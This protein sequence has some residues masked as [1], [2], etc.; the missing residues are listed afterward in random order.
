MLVMLGSTGYKSNDHCKSA[1]EDVL[2]ED[3]DN[4]TLTTE[5]NIQLGLYLPPTL[6]LLLMIQCLNQN[7]KVANCLCSV[8]CMSHQAVFLC[9]CQVSVPIFQAMFLGK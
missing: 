8:L 7:N 1:V 4:K 3:G 6:T 9:A 5:K 2:A